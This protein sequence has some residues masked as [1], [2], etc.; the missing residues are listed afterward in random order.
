M[1]AGS[2]ACTKALVR[3]PQLVHPPAAGPH[4]APGPAMEPAACAQPRRRSLLL[5][6]AA[7][8]PLATEAVHQAGQARVLP[9]EAVM[10]EPSANG[11]QAERG[12]P[13][14][15][16]PVTWAEPGG[17]AVV[18]GGGNQPRAAT[19]MAVHAVASP[20]VALGAAALFLLTA[21]DVFGGAP[22]GLPVDSL[23]LLP[24]YVDG[25]VHAWVRDSHGWF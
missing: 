15:D 24:R 20:A 2:G 18:P 21:F 1:L 10:G 7:G 19:S 25:P 4:A 3:R 9:G 5:C 17:A 8:D 13:A 12:A 23:H 6:Q 14:E 22:F 16:A 11:A